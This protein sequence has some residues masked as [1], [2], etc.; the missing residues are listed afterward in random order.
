MQSCVCH[1]SADFNSIYSSI[2]TDV[3]YSCGS[4]ATDDL[5][6]ASQVM[7]QYCNQA[8]VTVTF[9]T[10]TANLVNNYITDLPEMAYLPPCAQSALSEAVMGV[11]WMNASW[12]IIAMLIGIPGSVPMPRGCPALCPLR[13]QQECRSQ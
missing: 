3:A 6:S 10:P 7:D 12:T 9:S 4:S 13:V 2:S 11:V 5:W 1:A 8:D